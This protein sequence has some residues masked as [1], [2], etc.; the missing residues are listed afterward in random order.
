MAFSLRTF[1]GGY[2]ACGPPHVHVVIVGLTRRDQEPKEKRLFSYDN[3]NADPVES[4]HGALTAYLFDAGQ[5]S[6]RHLVV[7]E[8]SRPLCD[9]PRLVSGTQPIDDGNYIFDA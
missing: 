4:R 8:R 3:I 1:A 7:E 6:N 2:D 5:V 9:V